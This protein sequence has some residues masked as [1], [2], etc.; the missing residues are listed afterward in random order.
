[1]K[2]LTAPLIIILLAYAPFLWL[3]VI[4]YPHTDYWWSWVRSW[5]VLPGLPALLISRPL[6]IESAFGEVLAMGVAT[7]IGLAVLLVLSRRGPWW[8][9]ATSTATVVYGIWIA[10]ASHAVFV[11]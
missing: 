9:A 5:P 11:A 1:M 7:A 6:G 10:L 2:R 8:F 4:D 3:L